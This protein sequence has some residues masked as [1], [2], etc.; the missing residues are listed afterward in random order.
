MV[1]EHDVGYR[2]YATPH[3]NASTDHLALQNLDKDGRV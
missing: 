2:E 1:D 3:G